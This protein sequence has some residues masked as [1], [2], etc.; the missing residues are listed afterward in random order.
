MTTFNY[1]YLPGHQFSPI[2]YRL[3]N[4]K[5]NEIDEDKIKSC[6]M[7]KGQIE[8]SEIE[9]SKVEE[10]KICRKLEDKR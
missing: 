4:V 9:K 1:I 6:K 8:E 5:K 7:E 10:N 3:S 2:I